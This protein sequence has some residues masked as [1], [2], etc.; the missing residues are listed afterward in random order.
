MRND[1]PPVSAPLRLAD[2][3]RACAVG[4][5]MV[6]LDLARTRY[7]G[8][9]GP[10]CRTLIEVTGAGD[11]HAASLEMLRH[12][13]SVRALLAQRIL[14]TAPAAPTHRQPPLAAPTHSIAANGAASAATVRARDLGRFV[15]ATLCASAWLRWRS[16]LSIVNAVGALKCRCNSQDMGVHHARLQQAVAVFD[17][18]RPLAFTSRD[19]CLFDSIALTLFLARQNLAVQWIVGVSIRPFRAHAWV[20][21]RYEVLN[22]THE[23]VRR[24]TPLLVV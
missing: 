9:S 10:H 2:H 19:R 13:A 20:Q 4:D 11:A 24:F 7:L 16:L 22:D 8:L 12:S 18:L 23:N 21:H 17:H 1:A 5:Q 3:V 15:A 6:L 14:T